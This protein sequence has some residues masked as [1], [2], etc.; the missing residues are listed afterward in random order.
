MVVL[1]SDATELPRKLAFDI[2]QLK[3]TSGLINGGFAPLP[4]LG[5]IDQAAAA[6]DADKRSGSLLEVNLALYNR[7]PQFPLRN[8][9]GRHDVQV[10]RN[11]EPAPLP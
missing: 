6:Q 10:V 11:R 9:L 5:K 7:K 1:P 2:A 4:D 8:L 3:K